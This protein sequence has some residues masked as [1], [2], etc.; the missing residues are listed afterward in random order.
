MRFRLETFR[1]VGSEPTKTN[2]QAMRSIK[3]CAL[4]GQ[5]V[6]QLHQCAA[7]DFEI[8]GVGCLAVQGRSGAIPFQKRRVCPHWAGHKRSASLLAAWRT[9]LT[10]LESQ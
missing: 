6:N 5:R 3:D 10:L 2:Y 8:I 7:N 1:C 4:R 9:S